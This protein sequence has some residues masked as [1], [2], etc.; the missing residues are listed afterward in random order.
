VITAGDLSMSTSKE[1]VSCEVFVEF[2]TSLECSKQQVFE[3][4]T[5]LNVFQCINFFL[6]IYYV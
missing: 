3:R 1:H 5:G 2:E 6:N 4:K